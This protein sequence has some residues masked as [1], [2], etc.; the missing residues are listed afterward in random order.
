MKLVHILDIGTIIASRTAHHSDT[1]SV[2]SSR[3]ER[4]LP[5]HLIFPSLID[6]CLAISPHH[7][8]KL[9]TQIWYN[10]EGCAKPYR[11]RLTKEDGCRGTV[12]GCVWGVTQGKP[13]VTKDKRN[14]RKNKAQK[15]D[16]K[17]G[18]HGGGNRSGTKAR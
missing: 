3:L 16:A 7:E 2:A 5:H 14:K 9:C 6:H 17:D 4:K 18:K 11:V 1:P 15:D 10:C 12:N 13:E 8:A